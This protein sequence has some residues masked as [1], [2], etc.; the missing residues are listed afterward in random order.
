M[1]TGFEPRETSAGSLAIGF[2]SLSRRSSDPDPRAWR[3]VVERMRLVSRSPQAPAANR[4]VSSFSHGVSQL[5]SRTCFTNRRAATDPPHVGHRL[6]GSFAGLSGAVWCASRSA[7]FAHVCHMLTQCSSYCCPIRR[8]TELR[9]RSSSASRLVSIH[10]WTTVS[11]R[12]VG[13]YATPTIGSVPD[14]PLCGENSSTPRSRASDRLLTGR[15]SC[16]DG[17]CLSRYGSTTRQDQS[18]V[19]SSGIVVSSG[20]V[21]TYVD[22]RLRYVRFHSPTPTDATFPREHICFPSQ[23]RTARYTVFGRSRAY[24]LCVHRVLSTN[25]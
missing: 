10:A 11:G 25:R 5:H 16:G 7:C 14:G 17:P 23:S 4:A 21:V 1:P 19:F 2:E 8:V 15:A 13:R 22:A 9:E 3:P 6:S 12:W 20:Y 18:S 24:M